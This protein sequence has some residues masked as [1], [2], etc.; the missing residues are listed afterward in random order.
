VN[1]AS[2]STGTSGAEGKRK[3]LSQGL[4]RE[5]K[6]ILVHSDPISTVHKQASPVGK[7]SYNNVLLSCAAVLLKQ[8]QLK[9]PRFSAE[10]LLLVRFQASVKIKSSQRNATPHPQTFKKQKGK[11]VLQ[12]FLIMSA[13]KTVFKYSES[14]KSERT[15]YKPVAKCF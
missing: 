14:Q 8:E 2:L 6:V 4:E 1:K 11:Q 10:L 15:Y 5:E 13:R 3:L 12:L 9:A 7:S